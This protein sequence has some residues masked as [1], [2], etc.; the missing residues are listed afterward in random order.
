M[1]EILQYL[2]IV[3][4]G[5]FGV[6]ALLT[7]YKDNQGNI[8]GAGKIALVG[9]L[10]SLSMSVSLKYLENKNASQKALVE[11]EKTNAMLFTVTKALYPLKDFKVEAE[12]SYSLDH[13]LL[14][15]YA[16][17]FRKQAKA[18]REEFG[19]S[20]NSEKLAKYKVSIFSKNGSDPNNWMQIYFNSPL[21]EPFFSD[22]KSKCL[23][24]E[25]QLFV[26]IYR[27]Y[28]LSET[29]EIIPDSS[30]LNF[31]YVG[32]VFRVTTEYDEYKVGSLL[33]NFG[34]DR[35]YLNTPDVKQDITAISSKLT[36]FL[37]LIDSTIV[38]RNSCSGFNEFTNI[39]YIK[40]ID[41][42]GHIFTMDRSK[43]TLVEKNGIHLYGHHVSPNINEFHD[44]YS[45]QL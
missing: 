38:V 27:K 17:Q 4:S 22:L 32:M 23:L 12:V 6:Y 29:E 20:S 15:K 39:E 13:P 30:I 36:S 16:D 43:F 5:I 18:I 31:T 19:R 35:F 37:D 25:I 10:V 24:S 14:Y 33:Y 34:E 9:V 28:D 1:V 26:N 8:T 3:L 42:I 7:K 11:I 45:D 41:S 44:T 40:F 21:L 2:S